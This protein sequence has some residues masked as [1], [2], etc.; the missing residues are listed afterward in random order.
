MWTSLDDATQ[1]MDNPIGIDHN[2]STH[3]PNRCESTEETFQWLRRYNNK[4]CLF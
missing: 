2:S 1:R 3:A 4:G